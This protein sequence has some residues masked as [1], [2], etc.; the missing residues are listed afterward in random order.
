[1]AASAMPPGR[2]ERRRSRTQI[3]LSPRGPPWA[4]SRCPAAP[5]LLRVAAKASSS[6]SSLVRSPPGSSP[7]RLSQRRASCSSVG[8]PPVLSSVL[9]HG[10]QRERHDPSRTKVQSPTPLGLRDSLRRRPRVKPASEREGRSPS[11][12]SLSPTPLAVRGL[13]VGFLSPG[14]RRRSRARLQSLRSIRS[15]QIWV[16]EVGCSR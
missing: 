1:M 4:S 9:S 2:P 7:P 8:S 14:R 6:C 13:V 16:S 3:V 12:G 15:V 5:N 10:A 11:R